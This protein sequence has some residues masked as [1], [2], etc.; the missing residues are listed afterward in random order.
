MDVILE[1]DKF[2]S[3]VLKSTYQADQIPKGTAQAASFQTTTVSPERNRTSI[4][5]S[6]DQSLVF[7]VFFTLKTSS[8]AKLVFNQVKRSPFSLPCNTD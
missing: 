8:H 3:P 2:N 1:V 4:F 6:S 5:P 7:P